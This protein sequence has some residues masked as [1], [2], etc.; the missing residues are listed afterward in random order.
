MPERRPNIENRGVLGE[1]ANAQ[2]EIRRIAET[3]KWEYQEEATKL[4]RRADTIIDRFY[5]TI[6]TPHFQGRLPS[7]LIAIDSLRNRKVLA[8]YNLVPDEYGLNF[9]ITMNEQHY[10][11]EGRNRVWRYGEWAQMETL[12]HEIGHHWQQMLGEKPYEIGARVTHNKEF[13][14]K[15][16]QLGI[17]CHAE[18]FHS[19]VSELDSPFGLLMKEW[20]ITQPVGVTKDESNIHW[21]REFF[22]SKEKKG[23]STLM[24][25][26]CQCGYK[27]RVGRKT[28]PGATCNECNTQY[29]RADLPQDH[30]EENQQR[31]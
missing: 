29:F 14:E 31:G 8:A 12:V 9:K 18:G 21:F 3:N 26:E 7:V 13:R 16:E 10:V 6:H 1:E 17:H 11:K 30:G 2:Y 25:W 5:P 27:I 4:Y 22:K 23:R 24:K 20:G 15:M 28:W 19:K